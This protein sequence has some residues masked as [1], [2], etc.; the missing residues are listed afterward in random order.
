MCGYHSSAFPKFQLVLSDAQSAFRQ[1]L[2]EEWWSDR[3][4]DIVSRS[5]SY[6]IGDAYV[7]GSVVQSII[8]SSQ[9]PCEV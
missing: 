3:K 9:Q 6:N 8:E 1:L 7:A 4:N 5:N 2:A